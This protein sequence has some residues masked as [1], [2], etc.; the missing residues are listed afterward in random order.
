VENGS[1]L[2]VGDAAQ[3]LGRSTEQIRRY[4]REGR[5]TGRRIGGQWFIEQEALQSF[6]QSKREERTFLDR[7][8]SHRHPDPLGSVIG[9]ARGGGTNLAEGKHAYRRAAWWRR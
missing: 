4:L 2:T 7:L 1:L 6:R 9:I 8:R 5:L 3:Y